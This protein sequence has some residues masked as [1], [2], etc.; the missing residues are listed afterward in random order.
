MK[1]EIA[2]LTLR[3]Y[4]ELANRFISLARRR[5]YAPAQTVEGRF[6][7]CDTV[8]Q[9]KTEKQKLLSAW[10]SLSCEDPDKGQVWMKL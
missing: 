5:G 7:R 4:P 8:F 9:T 6:V 10:S 3:L 1:S 2:T